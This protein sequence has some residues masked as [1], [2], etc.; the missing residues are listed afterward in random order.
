[1]SRGFQAISAGGRTHDGVSSRQGPVVC[2][3]ARGAA[4]ADRS[5]PL[6]RRHGPHSG[7]AGT[8]RRW[9]PPAPAWPLPWADATGHC[10]GQ[11][12]WRTCARS[13]R[14][15]PCRCPPIWRTAMATSRSSSPR[16]FAWRPRLAWSAPRSKTA[17]AIPTG[18]I[19]CLP[20]AVARIQAA[21]EAARALPFPFMLTARAENFLHG[22]PDLDDTLARLAGVRGSR[23]RRAVRA[24]RARP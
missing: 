9:P 14:P 4:A 6:G 7:R 18:P 15:R 8:S 17:A 1:M 3:L 24:G 13:S 21:A 23:G 2:S 10:R 20:H 19:Y 5:Q 16:R 11:R 12:R 22:N